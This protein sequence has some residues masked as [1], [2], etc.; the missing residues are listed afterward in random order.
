MYKSPGSDQNPA[1][2]VQAGDKILHSEIH[3]LINSIWNKED[4]PDQRKESI[5]VLDNKKCDKIGNIYLLR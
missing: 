5:I 3:K 1:E 4:L 2:Q